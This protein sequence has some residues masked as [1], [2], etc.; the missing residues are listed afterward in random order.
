MVQHPRNRSERPGRLLTAAKGLGCH[1]TSAGDAMAK[2]DGQLRLASGHQ[3]RQAPWRPHPW[4][5]AR[6]ATTSSRHQGRGGCARVHGQGVTTACEVIKRMGYNHD[7]GA[8]AVAVLHD[9]QERLQSGRVAKPG[10][11]GPRATGCARSSDTSGGAP[12]RGACRFLATKV[13]GGSRWQSAA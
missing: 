1:A 13:P 5:P 11:C 3:S 12:V 10:D 9:G 6:R 7:A 8:C 2:A 4:R